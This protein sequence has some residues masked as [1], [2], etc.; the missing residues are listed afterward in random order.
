MDWTGL[1]C[2]ALYAALL[3]TTETKTGHQAA[4][5]PNLHSS[6]A[7]TWTLLAVDTRRHGMPTAVT[8]CQM[9]GSYKEH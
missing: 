8:G 9:T 5:L 6:G 7:D 2:H 1:I 4:A 3:A